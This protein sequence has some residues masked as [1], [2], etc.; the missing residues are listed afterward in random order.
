MAWVTFVFLMIR[1]P[2][3]STLFPYT[4]VF[5]SAPV[6]T[7]IV[8]EA[9]AGLGLKL[10]VAQPGNPLS[11]KVTAAV[12]PLEGVMLTVYVVPAPCTTLWEAGVAERMK[13]GT[14]AGLMA[15][16]TNA[17]RVRVP[18]TPVMVNA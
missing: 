12:K 6:P 5:R 18:L 7:V 1:R 10:A 8:E 17:V 11:L 9:V 2:P 13:S 4:T 3:R 16:V 14:G 15:R